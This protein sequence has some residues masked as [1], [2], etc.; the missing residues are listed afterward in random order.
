M[1]IELHVRDTDF[2]LKLKKILRSGAIKIIQSKD[3][4]RGNNIA[5]RIRDKEYLKQV[6]IPLFDKYLPLTIKRYDYLRFKE[7]LSDIIYY[8]DLPEY[9][10]P[11]IQNF[12]KEDIKCIMNAPY[13]PAWLIGFIEAEG[14][15]NIYKPIKQKNPIA[16]FDIGQTND[17]ARIQAIKEYLSIGARVYK[18]KEDYYRIKTAGASCMGHVIHFI[19][20]APIMLQGYK[21]IQFLS[22]LGKLNTIPTYSHL[23][24]SQIPY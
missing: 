3:P 20:N 15:F 22:L 24:I 7:A 11:V 9:S 4:Y 16:S 12:F 21:K 8:K 10:R 14:S 23:N 18:D 6:I 5:L 1:G 2:I 13:L 17:F 19:Y